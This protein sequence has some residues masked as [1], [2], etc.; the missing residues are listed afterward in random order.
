MDRQFNIP[1]V[2]FFFNRPDLILK[3]IDRI[4]SVKPKKIYLFSDGG[5]NDE[6]WEIVRGCRKAV[7]DRIDWD[8]EIV[9]NYAE[10][11]RGVYE[12]IGKGA[13]W[14]FKREE[15]AI[16]L[17]DDNLPE[18]TFFEY[19]EVMLEK[20]ENDYRI[21]WVCGT[22]YL[23]KY[24]P[25]DGSS[26]MFT[27]HLMPCGWA[28]WSKKFSEMYD[29]ELVLLDNPSV[30]DNLKYTYENKALF[31]QQLYTFKGTHKKLRTGK[32]VSWDHQM[33]FSIRANSTLGIAPCVNQIANIGVDERSTNGGNSMR[34][35]MTKRFC[36]IKSEAMI[37]PIKHPKNVMIDAEFE[38][39]TSKII[40][41]PLSKRMIV[42]GVRLVKPLFGFGKYDSVNRTELINKVK[43]KRSEYEQ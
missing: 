28:S 31:R 11:N 3:V 4:A 1:I 38:K 5:R 18:T 15:K 36:G 32:K 33:C 41:M 9:R 21:L 29:G 22:N 16:F 30:E 42:A 20:Y 24:R 13:L 26:Y 12:S 27:R 43:R 23:E 35:I 39:R 10:I 6:E 25:K 2:V 40:L 7:E 34:K 14:V 19:C 8:C 17:E 37:F